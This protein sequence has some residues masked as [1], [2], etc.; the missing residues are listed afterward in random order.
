MNIPTR[1]VL[2]TYVKRKLITARTFNGLTVYNY[3]QKCTYERAW[4]NV[5]LQARGLI[6]NEIDEL[7]ALPWPKFF[8]LGE[9]D[10]QAIPNDPPDS[11]TVKEDG[12]LGIGFLHNNE[13]WWSTRGSLESPQSDV[14]AV[15]WYDKFS[16]VNSEVLRGLTIFVE[17]VGPETRVII[18][19]YE[20]DLILLG[21]RRLDDGYDL[22]YDEITRL[23]KKLGMTVVKNAGGTTQ[24][25]INA[26]SKMTSLEE[27]FVLRWGDQRVK[28][29]SPAY[30]SVARIISGMNER[31]IADYWYLDEDLPAEIPEEIMMWAEDIFKSLNED[32]YEAKLKSKELADRFDSPRELALAERDNDYFS[33][34]VNLIKNRDI[35]YKLFVY[36]KRFNGRPRPLTVKIA[37]S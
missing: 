25:A 10:C 3:T 9:P 36:R 26:A 35:D 24:E 23:G 14:C 6:Y 32:I 21:A 22:S 7:V 15:I 11:V 29:K 34:A 5:T 18:P 12:S 17:I 19:Y 4:D 1:D 2:N 37:S 33:L 13:V 28:V 27:G 8:N 16:H 30:L 31:R 20:P